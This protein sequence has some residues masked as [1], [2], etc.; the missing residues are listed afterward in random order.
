MADKDGESAP[1]S[2]GNSTTGI[3]IGI[4]IGSV[5]GA[6]MFDDI[7]IGIAFGLPLGIAIGMLGQSRRKPPETSAEEG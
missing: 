1:A 5:I 7:A 2:G 3:V 6:L 4:V